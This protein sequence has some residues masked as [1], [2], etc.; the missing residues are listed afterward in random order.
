MADP[1]ISPALA[2][3]PPTFQRA[4][5]VCLSSLIAA[6]DSIVRIPLTR[7]VRSHIGRGGR[8]PAFPPRYRQNSNTVL[9]RLSES[10]RLQRS[11]PRSGQ[12]GSRQC[13]R[14]SVRS[15][16]TARALIPASSG[17]FLHHVRG[18][19]GA[20][21]ENILFP[22]HF[23]RTQPPFIRLGRR[24]CESFSPSIVRARTCKTDIIRYLA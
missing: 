14:R 5:L 24:I 1:D 4:L 22:L 23:S 16:E 3:K 2:P 11:I 15:S 8:L 12:C 17:C 20:T 6:R 18:S 7:A 19:Q 9:S 21:T 10:R 13:A